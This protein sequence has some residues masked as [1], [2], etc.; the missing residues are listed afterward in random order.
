V[1][2]CDSC[3]YWDLVDTDP[4][5][6]GE[7]HRHAPTVM[8]CQLTGE[9]PRDAGY[10]CVW[11]LTWADEWCGEWEPRRDQRPEM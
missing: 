7:C 5:P 11:P 9:S 2:R 3:R 10:H 8:L 1:E 4:S 6:D